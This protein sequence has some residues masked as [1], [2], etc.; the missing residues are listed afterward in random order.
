MSVRSSGGR[1]RVTL[2]R[3]GPR[4][5]LADVCRISSEDPAR[6]ERE[7]GGSPAQRLA[8]AGSHSL[9]LKAVGSH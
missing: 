9:L 1:D 4:R 6:T 5:L 7:L 3:P 8:R 2:G